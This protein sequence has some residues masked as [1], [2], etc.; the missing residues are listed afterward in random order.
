MTEDLTHATG[1]GVRFEIEVVICELSPGGRDFIRFTDVGI[2]QV[3]EDGV[4]RAGNRGIGNS[5][6]GVM[7]DNSIPASTGGSLHFLKT[8]VASSLMRRRGGRMQPPSF[9]S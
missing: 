9:R 2:Q 1:T 3:L 8:R 7:H 6:P 5:G 4:G